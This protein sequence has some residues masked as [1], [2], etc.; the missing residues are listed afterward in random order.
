M[1]LSESQLYMAL[2]EFI[3]RELVPLGASMDLTKQFAFGF[4]IGVIK[5]QM[6]HVVKSY[7]NKNELKIFEIIDS[8]NKINIDVIYNAAKDVLT[9]MQQVEFAGI[10]FKERDLNTL[11]SIMQKYA[12]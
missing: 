11:Y 3:E 2:N 10:I 1:K 6:E 12:N 9:R 5:Q 4:K 7:L 8:D